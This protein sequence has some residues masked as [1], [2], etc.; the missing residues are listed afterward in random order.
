MQLCSPLLRS[1]TV[2]EVDPDN[3]SV[4]LIG[5]ANNARLPTEGEP[6]KTPLLTEQRI[7]AVQISLLDGRAEW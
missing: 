1:H 3:N 7:P 4:N 2:L 5:D 6:R